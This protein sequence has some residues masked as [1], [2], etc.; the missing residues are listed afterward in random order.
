MKKY[1]DNQIILI[2]GIITALYDYILRIIVENDNG[3]YDEYEKYDFIRALKP[4]F[5][6]TPIADAM[7]YAGVIG[8]ATKAII[9]YVTDYPHSYRSNDV[10]RYLFI[11]TVISGL[12]GIPIDKLKLIPN[13]S[14]T[15]Y[16]DTNRIYEDGVSGF[17]VT[18]NLLLFTYMS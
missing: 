16:K 5:D 17:I 13:L 2:A 18:C 15:Y 12:V 14:E 3:K 8:V 7:L 9:L 11:S 10:S 4:Y 6:K 1:T